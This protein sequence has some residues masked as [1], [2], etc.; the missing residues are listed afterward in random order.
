VNGAT[1]VGLKV[2]GLPGALTATLGCILPSLIL[3]SLLSWI[4]RRY[5]EMSALQSVLGSLRPAV[6]ALIL[7]AGVNMLLQNIFGGKSI[8]LS[9]ISWAG[10]AL[11]TGAFLAMRNWKCNP[12][13]VMATCGVSGLILGLLGVF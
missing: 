11:F 2:A 12:I 1:F 6:V 4:Y 8:T 5:R 13:L 9:E 3:V 7:S 10:A